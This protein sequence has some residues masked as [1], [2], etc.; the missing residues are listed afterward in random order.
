MQ[1]IDHALRASFATQMNQTDGLKQRRFTWAIIYQRSWPQCVPARCRASC[2]TLSDLQAVIWYLQHFWESWTI[3][4]CERNSLMNEL[5]SLCNNV[6]TATNARDLGLQR[7]Y[8]GTQK[9]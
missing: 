9:R 6:A 1:G 5:P 8:D 3:C 7:Q 2:W 4:S